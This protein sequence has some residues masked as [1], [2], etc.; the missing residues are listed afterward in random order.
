MAAHVGPRDAAAA[1]LR[2]SGTGAFLCPPRALLAA[3]R[4]GQHAGL[5]SDDAGEL[6]P[7]AAAADSSPVPQA[8]DRDGAEIDAAFQALRLVPHRHGAADLVP[9]HLPRSSGSGAG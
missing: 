4:A 1:W 8:A 2:G 6:L 5:L 7:P 3:L 9:P